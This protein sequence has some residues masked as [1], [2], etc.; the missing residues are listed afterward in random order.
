MTR[1]EEREERKRRRE[2]KRLER[3]ER[4]RLR[5]ERKRKK[6]LA[7]QFIEER[8]R[9]NAEAFRLPQAPRC[10]VCGY[11]AWCVHAIE[12]IMKGGQTE[13]KR[14]ERAKGRGQ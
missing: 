3:E 11:E 5:E 12:K 10:E 6:E 8:K 1:K 2:M 7:R 14:F 13:E 9:N 4:K